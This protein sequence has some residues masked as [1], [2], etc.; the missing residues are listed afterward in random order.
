[1]SDMVIH[2]ALRN[3]ELP[4]GAGKPWII[5]DYD[6]CLGGVIIDGVVRP[7]GH[8][9]GVVLDEFGHRMKEMGFDRDDALT[10]QRRIDVELCKRLGFSDRRRFGNSLAQTYESMARKRGG[11]HPE[12]LE[13][14]QSLGEEVFNFPYAALPGA[15]E[16]LTVLRPQYNLAVYTKGDVQEQRKKMRDSGVSTRVDKIFIT[17][18]KTHASWIDILSELGITA[19]QTG[20][21]W[22]VGNSPIGDV[23]IPLEL[24]LNTILVKSYSWAFEDGDIPTPALG[25]EFVEVERIRDVLQYIPYVARAT[26]T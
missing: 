3:K 16:V 13:D 10:Q 14:F 12:V 23:S 6:D 8:A 2:D 17:N 15:L 9:Y 1:M 7:N 5:F 19:L 4:S 21:T 26:D 11:A 24:G 20:S 18:Q 25:R 22:A